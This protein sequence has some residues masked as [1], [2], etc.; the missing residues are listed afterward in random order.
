[1][2][3]S[4]RSAQ[5]NR[6]NDIYVFCCSFEHNVAAKGKWLAFVSTT[7]ETSRPE[8]ELLPG[9]PRRCHGQLLASLQVHGRAS[10]SALP[11]QLMRCPRTRQ[12]AAAG[13]ALLGAVEEKF[14]EVT[15]I[16]QPSDD[17][18]SSKA[19]VSRSYDATSHFETEMDDVLDLYA[20]ITGKRLD[21]SAKDPAKAEGA[22]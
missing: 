18:R 15:D 8:Q 9:T 14:V 12:R 20:R 19:F 21:L 22:D 5:V 3:P 17:G 16:L 2:G 1:M 6:Q 7:V 13:L 11:L 4:V 10:P